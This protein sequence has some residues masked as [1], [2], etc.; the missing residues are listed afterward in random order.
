MKWVE[1]HS[2]RLKV[3]LTIFTSKLGPILC[4]TAGSKERALTLEQET[5]TSRAKS[6]QGMRQLALLQSPVLS[7][8]SRPGQPVRGTSPG[9][10]L[11]SPR[12]LQQESFVLG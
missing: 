9:R 2:S 10:G 11:W 12:P 5:F 4:W 6:F 1:T 3:T 7:A 8:E